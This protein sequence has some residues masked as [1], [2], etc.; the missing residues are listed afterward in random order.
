MSLL[1]ISDTLYKLKFKKSTNNTDNCNYTMSTC[2]Y[3]FYCEHAK[4]TEDTFKSYPTHL[5]TVL[6]YFQ[7]LYDFACLHVMTIQTHANFIAELCYCFQHYSKV[8][9]KCSLKD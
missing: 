1:L 4:L 6:P 5:Y 9:I 7:S 8:A 3:A 2:N